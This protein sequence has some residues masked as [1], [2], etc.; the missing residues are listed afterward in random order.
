MVSTYTLLRRMW[1]RP[2]TLSLPVC[3]VV[4]I[5]F[6]VGVQAV[7][8]ARA[9]RL[10]AALD[11]VHVGMPLE[12]AKEILS[13]VSGHDAEIQRSADQTI[14]RFR[15]AVTHMGPDDL[16]VAAVDGIV[17]GIRFSNSDHTQDMPALRSML[18]RYEAGSK[19]LVFMDAMGAFLA[20]FL[21]PLVI[22]ELRSL[23]DSRGRE[24][25]IGECLILLAVGSLAFAFLCLSRLGAP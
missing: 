3:L 13:E 2:L 20:T 19:A 9:E 18:E 1:S 11:D 23:R 10:L 21:L 16:E 7:F 5:A 8:S 25:R 4:G 15:Y 12:E 6:G 14:L 22:A 24:Q 17:T